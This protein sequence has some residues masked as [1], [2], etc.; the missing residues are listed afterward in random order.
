MPGLGWGSCPSA[1]TGARGLCQDTSPCSSGPRPLCPRRLPTW[2]AG[3][4]NVGPRAT[5]SVSPAAGS[6]RRKEGETLAIT[7]SSLPRR[8]VWRGL[9]RP[10]PGSPPIWPWGVWVN[11]Q[12]VHFL[13]SADSLSPSWLCFSMGASGVLGQQWPFSCA[14]RQLGHPPPPWPPAARLTVFRSLSQL[15]V[16][17]GACLPAVLSGLGLPSPSCLPFFFFPNPLPSPSKNMP[18]P[19]KFH[20]PAIVTFM[21]FPSSNITE[22]CLTSSPPADPAP[23]SPHPCLSPLLPVP[24]ICCLDSD[25]FACLLNPVPRCISR[26]ALLCERQDRSQVLASRDIVRWFPNFQSCEGERGGAGPVHG[27]AGSILSAC[28]CQ[29][30]WGLSLQ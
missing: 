16:S 20:S 3:L 1:P 27:G 9:A 24:A 14:S 29:A 28:S 7:V 30:L 17:L 12:A 5:S 22:E 10:A 21:H 25:E 19:R 2:K 4:P 11:H 8:A 18:F 6:W 23:T 15:Q 13:F 26:T